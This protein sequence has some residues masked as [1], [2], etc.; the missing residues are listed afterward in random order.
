MK[1]NRSQS[2]RPNGDED[3]E[4]FCRALPGLL[5]TDLGLFVAFSRGRLI[6][7][8]VDELALVKR[9]NPRTSRQTC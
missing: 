7:K 6:D 4:A 9:G 8:D 2:D 3:F 1:K 5:K